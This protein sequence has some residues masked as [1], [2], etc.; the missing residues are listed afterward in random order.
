MTYQKC[1]NEKCE[2]AAQFAVKL[3]IPAMGY[4]QEEQRS[5]QMILGLKICKEHGEEFTA[6][7]FLSDDEIKHIF[8]IMARSNGSKIPPDFKRA[9]TRLISLDSEEFKIFEQMSKKK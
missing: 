6:E 3:F 8:R 9:W 1:D 5:L 7:Q 4:P 2:L